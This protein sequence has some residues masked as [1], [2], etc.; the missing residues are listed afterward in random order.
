MMT[1]SLHIMLIIIIMLI[2]SQEYPTPAEAG[3]DG[4]RLQR[5]PCQ[6][7]VQGQADDHGKYVYIIC[8]Q[9]CIR[10]DTLCVDLCPCMIHSPACMT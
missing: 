10:Y 4:E 7:G 1:I 2:V 5:K 9:I 6:R 3:G 8:Q